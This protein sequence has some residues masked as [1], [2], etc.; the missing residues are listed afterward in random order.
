M[1][2]HIHH[3]NNNNTTTQPSLS[4][5]PKR[6]VAIIGGGLVGTLAT[7][8]FAQRGWDVN[9]F[10]LRKDPRIP[11]NSENSGIFQRSINLALSVRGL[12]ALSKPNLDLEKIVL[13]S[14]IPMKGRMI[15]IGKDKLSSQPYGSF[16]ENIYSVERNFL[17]ESL[18]NTVESFNNVKIYFQHQLKRCDFDKGLLEFEN[19]EDGKLVQYTADLIIGADGV[20]STVRRQLMRIINMNYQQ[21]YI[22]HIYCELTIPPKVTEKGNETEFIM[23]SNHLHIWPRHSFMLIALPNKNKSFTCTLFMPHENFDSIK[24]EDDLITFFQCNFPDFIQLIGEQQL[25]KEFFHNPKGSLLSIKC[26]PYHYRNRAIFIGDAA[27]CMVPFYGQG[28]N[29]GFQDVELLDSIFDKYNITSFRSDDDKLNLALE[30]FTN[31]RQPDSVAI[32]DLAMYNYI[33]MRSRVTSPLY[34]IRKKVEDWLHW[35]FPRR[36]VPLYT[37]ISFSTM[38]YSDAIQRWKRQR[39]IFNVTWI[40]VSTGIAIS[41]FWRY[42]Y[43]RLRW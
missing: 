30:E 12:S 23:D 26:K 8:Y 22:P 19:K 2:F 7:L 6:Y 18:F 28:M 11:E 31:I 15:H 43:R 13:E 36:F 1:S 24:T 21:E 14:A 42:Y 27:H 5:V 16:G 9:L 33:E 38:R 40:T 37:M 3:R 17:L 34:L 32:C 4:D 41:V 39:R 10:E 25:K 29:C 20:H 35:L